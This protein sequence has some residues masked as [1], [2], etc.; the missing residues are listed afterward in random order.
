MPLHTI[1]T[2]AISYS[3]E[4]GDIVSFAMRIEHPDGTVEEA[5]GP[6]SAATW[7]SVA[8]LYAAAYALSQV[9]PESAGTVILKTGSTGVADAIHG[10]PLDWSNTTRIS[11]IEGH[12]ELSQVAKR[13]PDLRVEVLHR[14]DPF[15]MEM[16]SLAKADAVAYGRERLASCGIILDAEAA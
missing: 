16:Q 12:H 6:I 11:Q 1:I 15:L 3:R 2:A 5:T 10:V 7:G 4:V 9:D 14:Y 13:F 8:N